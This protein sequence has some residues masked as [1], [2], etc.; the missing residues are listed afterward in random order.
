MN[1]WKVDYTV[2]NGAYEKR[3]L[4][5]VLTRVASIDAVDA[6]LCNQ[7]YLRA[8]NGTLTIHEATWLCPNVSYLPTDFML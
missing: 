1:L 3:Q 7:H 2:R 8:G 6:V 5:Y 4:G